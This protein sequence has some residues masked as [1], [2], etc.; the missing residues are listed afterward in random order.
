MTVTLR[1]ARVVQA[2][3]NPSAVQLMPVEAVLPMALPAMQVPT[4]PRQVCYQGIA[5]GT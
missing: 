1:L 2:A 4:L 3:L 5:E